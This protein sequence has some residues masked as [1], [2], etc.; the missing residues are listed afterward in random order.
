MFP[1]VPTGVTG[2]AALG[3]TFTGPTVVPVEAG[4]LTIVAIT[5]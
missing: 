4:K 2:M 1:N 5:N 3:G